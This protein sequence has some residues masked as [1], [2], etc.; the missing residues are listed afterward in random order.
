MGFASRS[1]RSG[2]PISERSAPGGGTTSKRS[3][4]AGTPA[5]IQVLESMLSGEHDYGFNADASRQLTAEWQRLED[6][7]RPDSQHAYPAFIL[8]AFEAHAMLLTV[9]S[10]TSPSS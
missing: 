9:L 3:I 6:L 10:H 4:V 5:A 7:P 2:I 8:P 1:S